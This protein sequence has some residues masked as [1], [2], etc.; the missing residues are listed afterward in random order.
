MGNLKCSIQM[1]P[2]LYSIPAIYLFVAASFLV[3][4]IVHAMPRHY[5]SILI[6]SSKRFNNNLMRRIRTDCQE[7]S[8]V[9][10]YKVLLCV[11]GKRF[12]IRADLYQIWQWMEKW[13]VR[14]GKCRQCVRQ[15]RSAQTLGQQRGRWRVELF[16]QISN[17]ESVFVSFRVSVRGKLKQ[18]KNIR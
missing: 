4:M 13:R 1:N 7:K 6:Q 17:K 3:L 2:Q 9:E 5:M 11:L 18:L 14:D 16:S 10:N 12:Y 15:A 8:Q